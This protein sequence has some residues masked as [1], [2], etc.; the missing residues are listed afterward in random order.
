M[1]D[2]LDG[3]STTMRK[4]IAIAAC[5]AAI[6]G[7]ALGAAVMLGPGD[8]T[9]SSH[10]EAP[11]IAEDPGADLT[12]VYAFRSPDK[13]GTVTIM[14][15]VIPGEDPAAGP[16]W[17]TFS[18]GARYNLK[19]DTTGDVKP[20]VIYR[21]QFTRKTG[22]LFLGDTAQPFTVTRVEKGRSTVVARGTTPP[23]NIGK[24]STPAYGSLVAKS[25]V[26]FD[27]GD[28]KAFA[29]QRD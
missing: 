23:N 6:T 1:T 16:N 7:A 9:A 12:D 21:F 24:R 4:G 18:P 20:D 25:I 11:L 27:G 3:R 13:P 10:R 26:S 2:H 29:G 15:N 22:Q 8:G 19:I 17:Y 28:S 14:A 5:A